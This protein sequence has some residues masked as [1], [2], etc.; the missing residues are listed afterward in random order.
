MDVNRIYDA[1]RRAH[2]AGD[3]ESAQKLAD[4]IKTLPSYQAP[5][6]AQQDA[7]QSQLQQSQED[8]RVGF[9]EGLTGSSKR[10]LSDSTTTLESL[11]MSPEEAA[12]RGMKRGDEITER[13][14]VSFEKVKELY[15]TEGLGA[16]AK[17]T[18]AQIPAAFGEQ[19]PFIGSIVAGARLGLAVAG[20]YGAIAGS[21][22]VPFLQA[23]GGAMERKA[24]TQYLEENK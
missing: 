13:S 9:V 7:I 16:A 24:Q 5:G 10:L 2:E 6:Q 19:T 22:L 8:D 4:F 18:L 14:C 21:L 17:E 23:S 12:L 1:F 15:E 20:P 3:T 11:F